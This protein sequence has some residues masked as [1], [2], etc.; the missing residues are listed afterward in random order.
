MDKQLCNRCAKWADTSVALYMLITHLLVLVEYGL[1]ICFIHAGY[2]C[3]LSY[4][5]SQKLPCSHNS[6]CSL[7]GISQERL[8]HMIAL[9]HM[10]IQYG[11]FEQGLSIERVKNLYHML[12]TLV[13]QCRIYLHTKS[14]FKIYD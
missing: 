14:T 7:P 12:K 10:T 9:I 2:R 4:L 3:I 6:K 11:G 13:G 5:I 8:N 1:F